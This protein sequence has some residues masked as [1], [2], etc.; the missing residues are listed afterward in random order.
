MTPRTLLL[1]SFWLCQW[2]STVWAHRMQLLSKHPLMRPFWTSWIWGLPAHSM[3]LFKHIWPVQ[4]THNN[5]TYDTPD[6]GWNCDIV[7]F[8]RALHTIIAWLSPTSIGQQPAE[9]LSCTDNTAS[10]SVHIGSQEERGLQEPVLFNSC[11][12]CSLCSTFQCI[13]LMWLCKCD[14][15]PE[16]IGQGSH[17]WI[18]VRL[19]K[20]ISLVKQCGHNYMF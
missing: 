18:L 9:A 5:V 3:C 8:H 14:H 13:F 7:L 19:K 11:L 16:E 1:G 17:C 6:N 4:A 10:D 20:W 15:C 12:A 2:L